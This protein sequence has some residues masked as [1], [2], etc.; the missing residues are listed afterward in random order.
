MTTSTLPVGYLAKIS[1][2]KLLDFSKLISQ[3]QNIEF[4]RWLYA[5]ILRE[6]ERRKRDGS[7]EP[8]EAQQTQLPIF[9]WSNSEIGIALLRVTT[10]SFVVDDPALSDYVN[11]LAGAI[12]CVTA[13]R[14]K[15]S[16]NENR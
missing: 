14:L 10:L 3:I 5:E 11:Q 1:D 4:G 2:D 13:F 16:E 12:T 9:D 8:L 15:E 6:A 7:D